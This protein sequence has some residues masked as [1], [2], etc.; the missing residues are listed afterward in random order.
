MQRIHVDFSKPLGRIKPMHAVGQPPFFGMD[1]SHC[2]YLKAANIPYSRLHDVGGAYGRNV[3][4]DIPNIFRNFDADENDEASYH[5]EFTDA[6][7][8]ALITYGVQPYFRLGVTIENYAEIRAYNVYPPKDF[9]KWARV[10]EHIIRHYNEGWAN[11]FTY[12]IEYWEIWNEPEGHPD[13]QGL[14][15]WIGTRE[16]YFELYRVAATHLKKC[17]GDKIKVGGFAST[18]FSALRYEKSQQALKT[19]NTEGLTEREAIVLHR[20]EYYIAFLE[21]LKKYRPPLDFF[22]WHSY[23]AVEFNLIQQAYVEKTLSEAGYSDVEI[24]LNEWNTHHSFE[25]RG[26]A[27]AAAHSAAAMCSMQKTKM[28]MMCFYDARLG[29]STYAGLFSPETL[30]PYPTYDAFWAFGA[31][32]ALGTEVQMTGEE[33]GIYATAATD[34]KE[35]AVFVVNIGARKTLSLDLCGRYFAYICKNGKR[36]API[37]IDPASF[38]LK[39]NE[40]VFFTTQALTI[41]K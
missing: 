11:G 4:V 13:G 30:R 17:F 33:N 22:S 28:E 34:G 25:T 32:Y 31:L 29:I 19:G 16:Q 37:D 27:A 1:F 7:I 41:P 15:M 2:R 6:L 8:S 20:Q 36:I 38:V 23:E 39:K 14:C 12:G 18:G 10:C 40:F 3:F 24:H 35:N 26:S 5:F 21:M 9:L